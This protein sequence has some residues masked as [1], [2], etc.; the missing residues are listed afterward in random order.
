[1]APWGHVIVVMHPV[2]IKLEGDEEEST[3][4][5]QCTDERRS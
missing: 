5:E 3:N 4:G 2:K 1:M